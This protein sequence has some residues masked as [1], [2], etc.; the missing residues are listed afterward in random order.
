MPFYLKS[1]V[2]KSAWG[3]HTMDCDLPCKT[4]HIAGVDGDLRPTFPPACQCWR[5]LAGSLMCGN[6]S[7]YTQALG[8]KTKVLRN[9]VLHSLLHFFLLI[10][11]NSSVI[12]VNTSSL[13]IHV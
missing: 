5:L 2:E 3:L 10:F 7:T 9:K 8:G 13:N 6:M 1:N 12:L 11:F 4:T